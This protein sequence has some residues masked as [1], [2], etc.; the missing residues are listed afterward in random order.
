M[1][2]SKNSN[3]FLCLT[4]VH[5]VRECV[6]ECAPDVAGDC[7]KRLRPLANSFE[8]LIEVVK[9]PRPGTSLFLVVLVAACSRSA[10]ARGRTMNRRSI[11]SNAAYPVSCEA[12]P[13]RH[14]SC[15]RI[16]DW[17]RDLS[18]VGQGFPGANPGREPYSELL[19][20]GPTA[21]AVIDLFIDRQVVET[22]RRQ[23]QRFWHGARPAG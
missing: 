7:G 17:P 20:F 14:P 21:T 15:R 13:G 23:R 6:Q 19:Q 12:A 3:R 22:G 11:R 16:L 18:A 8:H 5:G 1:Q 10:P 4:E 9:E 2:H